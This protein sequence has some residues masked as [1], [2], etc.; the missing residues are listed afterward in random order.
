M[1]LNFLD[2]TASAAVRSFSYPAKPLP[3]VK[4]QRYV[5]DI[6]VKKELYLESA[7]NLGTPQ[8]FYDETS[9][10]DTINVLTVPLKNTWTG[11][12]CSMP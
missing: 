3:D 6:L 12:G 7:S 4:I 10:E 2:K 1:E 9:I 5:N 8:Y 11:S